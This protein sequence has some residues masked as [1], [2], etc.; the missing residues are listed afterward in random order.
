MI[1][2]QRGLG[3]FFYKFTLICLIISDYIQTNFHFLNNDKQPHY[4]ATRLFEIH[5]H[6]NE[7]G[8]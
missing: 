7:S 1:Q 8:I 3:L 6:F 5:I 4:K 2:A